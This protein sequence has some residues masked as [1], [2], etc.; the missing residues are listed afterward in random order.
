MALNPA[1]IIIDH[2]HFQYN[3]I[4]LGLAVSWLCALRFKNRL[5]KRSLTSLLEKHPLC[6]RRL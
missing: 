1:L 4:S 3:G 2:G 6:R 5:R